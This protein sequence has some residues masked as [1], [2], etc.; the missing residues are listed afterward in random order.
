MDLFERVHPTGL[1]HGTVTIMLGNLPLEH[2]TFRAEGNYSDGRRPDSVVFVDTV[3]EDLKRRDFT[4]NAMAWDPLEDQLVDPFG[5]EEDLAA[6]RLR[7]VGNAQERLQE[8]ALR[9]L[10][11]VRFASTH[12][13]KPDSALLTAMA[14]TAPLLD[15]IATERI[16]DELTKILSRSERPSGAFQMMAEQG[17]IDRILPELRPM[18]GQ[19][20][21][22]FHAYDVWDH[23]LA[24]LDACPPQPVVLRW[25]ALFHDI[26]KPPTAEEHPDR[27]GEFRF[28]GHEKTS[29]EMTQRIADRLRFSRERQRRLDTIVAHHMIHPT[30]D[31]GDGAIRRLLSKLPGADLDDFLAFKRADVSGKGT[32]DLPERLADVDQLEERLRAELARGNA[33]QRRDLAI[34]SQS[35]MDLAGR[36]GGPWLGELQK[37]LLETVLEQ[38]GLN[39]EAS[40][41]QL[42]AQWLESN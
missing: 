16:E 7:A 42:A 23:T 4:V 21:N 6:G 27:P 40:L 9:I 35:L 29:V 20:Q 13:L 30:P 38:P 2:T 12:H 33:L 24:V 3:E 37:H 32:P 17:I 26:G 34:S 14:Q 19:A 39:E 36:S 41:A 5:G 15:R 31:W 1:G 25:A 10:R 11:A 28:F 18:K 8:D 22:R